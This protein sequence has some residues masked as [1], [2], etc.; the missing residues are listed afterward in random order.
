MIDENKTMKLFGYA[1]NQLSS[2][3][4]KLIIKVCDGC[5]EYKVIPK[6]AYHDLCKSCTNKQRYKLPKPKFIKEINRFIPNTGIDRILTIE[7]FG[8]D[9]VDLKSKSKRKVITICQ[10]CDKIKEIKFQNYHNLC[11]NCSIKNKPSK[12]IGILISCGFQRINRK[13]FTEFLTNQR[14]C[15]LFNNE[16]KEKIRNK[17]H[18]K[19]FIC[20]KEQDQKLDVHHVNYNKNCLCGQSCEFV[21]LCRSCHMKTNGSRQYWENLIIGYLYPERYFMVDL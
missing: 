12:E 14:Y 19:C 20:G 4:H 10:N 18:N 1:S 11:Y 16:F 3:S 9:P 6:Y 13:E 8:Y 17:F 2:Q 5:G 15:S 7:K 21:P